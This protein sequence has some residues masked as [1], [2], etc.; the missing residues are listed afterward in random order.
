MTVE[1]PREWMELMICCGMTMKKM[2][3]SAF[4]LRK[5]KALIV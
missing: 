5:M 2:G 1:G 3:M 4:S